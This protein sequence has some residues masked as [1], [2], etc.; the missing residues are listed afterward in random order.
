M[1]AIPL[2]NLPVTI[3]AFEDEHG[4]AIVIKSEDNRIGSADGTLTNT[5]TIRVAQGDIPKVATAHPVQIADAITRH[6]E[7][8]STHMDETGRVFVTDAASGEKHPVAL[9]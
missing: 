9:D 1:K 6:V 4:F 7:V 5:V 2:E 8:K 3:S